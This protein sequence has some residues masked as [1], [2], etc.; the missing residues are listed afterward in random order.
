MVRI[1]PGEPIRTGVRTM[2]LAPSR[3]SDR[4]LRDHLRHDEEQVG[5]AGRLTGG[6][7]QSVRLAA[8]MRLV[9]EEMRDEE[10]LRRGDLAT[11]GAAEPGQV[12]V[13]Q[14]VVDLLRPARNVRV[15]L[16]AGGTQ[17][18]PISDKVIALFDW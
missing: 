10:T 9:I 14:C 13:E 5:V 4:R 18:G 8:V 3:I 16:V 12:G 17:F 7:D 2:I 6:G 15:R 1:R 11:R